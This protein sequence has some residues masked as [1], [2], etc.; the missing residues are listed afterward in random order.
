MKTSSPRAPGVPPLSFYSRLPTWLLTRW[1]VKFYTAVLSLSP[2]PSPSLCIWTRSTC[3][4]FVYARDIDPVKGNELWEFAVESVFLVF[5]RRS[6]S[7]TTRTRG[8]EST[9]RW[10]FNRL[11]IYRTTERVLRVVFRSSVLFDD[12]DRYLAKRQARR[13]G[14]IL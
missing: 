3:F 14:S 9:E 1:T 12:L 10:T 5:E 8:L 13:C 6:D 11:P 7:K 2:S 4:L